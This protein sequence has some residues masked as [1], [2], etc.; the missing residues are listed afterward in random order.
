MEQAKPIIESYFSQ[1]EVPKIVF[2]D[3]IASRVKIA[4]DIE[5]M[6]QGLTTQELEN[7]KSKIIQA[8]RS[9]NFRKLF[10]QIS[11]FCDWLNRGK[12]AITAANLI[13][14]IRAERNVL[15]ISYLVG[16]LA[17]AILPF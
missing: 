12:V 17:E 11:Y 4:K 8:R 15:N 3:D 7:L 2:N 5:A 6:I 9:S 10:P 13:Q 1:E 16:F 14:A